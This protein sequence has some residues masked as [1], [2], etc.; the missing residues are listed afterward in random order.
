MN[1]FIHKNNVGI[2]FIF[3]ILQI[4]S[5]LFLLFLFAASVNNDD[6]FIYGFCVTTMLHR[7]LTHHYICLCI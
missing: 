4:L 3:I 2:F 6:D 5:S 1:S 7:K